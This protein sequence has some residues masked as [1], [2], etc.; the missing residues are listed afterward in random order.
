MG[1]SYLAQ[2]GCAGEGEPETD[3]DEQRGVIK[4]SPHLARGSPRVRLSLYQGILLE[5]SRPRTRVHEFMGGHDIRALTSSTANRPYACLEGTLG[6]GI[7][8]EWLSLG[9]Q[10]PRGRIPG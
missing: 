10:F 5:S 6:R 7:L 9:L 2:I 3:E 8:L 1:P 4:T